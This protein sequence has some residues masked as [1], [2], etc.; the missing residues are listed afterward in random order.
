MLGEMK[1]SDLL[2]CLQVMCGLWRYTVVSCHPCWSRTFSDAVAF[3]R[4]NKHSWD[5]K[6]WYLW[7]ESNGKE[8]ENMMVIRDIHHLWPLI[9]KSR[10][11]WFSM[12]KEC[13]VV[14]QYKE[15]LW[16]SGKTQSPNF[17][18]FLPL[19]YIDQVIIE[20]EHAFF[21]MR[22]SQIIPC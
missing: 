10:N 21:R 8:E 11:M 2:I 12:Q 17:F 9:E 5:P 3:L 22:Y 15:K 13:L 16:Y 4:I 7:V 20:S 18:F 19:N 6:I 14:T 1:F